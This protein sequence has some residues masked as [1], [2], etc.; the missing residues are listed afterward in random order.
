MPRTSDYVKNRVIALHNQG[1]NFSA[2]SHEVKENEGITVYRCPISKIV[3][4]FVQYGMLADKPLPGRK[5]K[6]VNEHRD[7][8]DARMEE[9]HELTSPG[10]INFTQSAFTGIY[11]IY[12]LFFVCLNAM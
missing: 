2:I 12:G 7:F 10:E 8:I 9:N 4:K 3:K 6:V 1:L 11:F 5:P